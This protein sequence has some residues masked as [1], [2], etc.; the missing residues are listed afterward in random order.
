MVDEAIVHVCTQALGSDYTKKI[1]L[2]L[3]RAGPLPK[4]K[5][6]KDVDRVIVEIAFGAML[7]AAV[8]DDQLAIKFQKGRLLAVKAAK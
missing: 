2:A 6:I 3:L 7:V 5:L 4:T 8:L 1:I